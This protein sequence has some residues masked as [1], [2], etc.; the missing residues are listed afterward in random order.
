MKMS[1]K[2]IEFKYNEERGGILE[3]WKDGEYSGDIITYPGTFFS[4][5]EEEEYLKTGRITRKVFTLDDI[6]AFIK[7]ELWIFAMTYAKK[8]PHEYVVRGKIEGTDEEF[9]SVVNYI[10][11]EG[12]T[13]YFWNHPNKY[14]FVD[15]Y[16]YWVMRD[17]EDDPTTILNRCK[18]DEYKYTIM[19]KGSLGE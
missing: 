19:W 8:A 5:E 17:S 15:G 18:V 2:S 1:D 16:Q 10:Q 14:I 6:R 9:M 11:K 7:K 13:M 3:A 4:K 12:V